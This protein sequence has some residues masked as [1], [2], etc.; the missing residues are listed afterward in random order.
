MS[1]TIR[2]LFST[3]RKIDRPIEKVIDYQRD[4]PDWLEREIKEY[5]VTDNVE[6]CF[7]KFVEH[8]GAGVRT[9]DITEVGIW[10][11]GFYGS[12]KSSFTKY[13]GFALDPE[14][15]VNGTPFIDLLG[16]RLKSPS[17][18]SEL[19]TLAKNEPT[20]VIMLDL[21]AEQL[22]DTATAPVTKVLYWKVLQ[23]IGFSKEKKLAELEF[24][25]DKEGRYE[26][27]QKAYKKK[28]PGKGE[29]D[30]IHNDPLIA[31]ARADQLVPEFF[32]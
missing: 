22:A 19:N 32:S 28:F 29:W 15:K 2:Q 14:R 23:K 21:G 20:A 4:D 9:G 1:E 27:F 12:G 8:F 10:V 6:A 30:E 11:S 5:E 17:V 16:D 18:K 3:D 24:R 31:M 26:D 13:L 25:L 7:K